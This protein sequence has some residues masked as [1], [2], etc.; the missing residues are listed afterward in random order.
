MDDNTFYGPEVRTRCLVKF[1]A[2]FDNSCYWYKDDDDSKVT[3]GGCLSN[4]NEWVFNGLTPDSCRNP[5]NGG[6]P[7]VDSRMI[8][9]MGSIIGILFHISDIELIDG[10][11]F[12]YNIAVFDN[13]CYWYK[14][15]DDSKVTNGGCLSNY[16]EWVFNGL[17]PD[18]CRNPV[19]GGNPPVDS[20]MIEVMGS[21][22][23]IL[24][25]ISDIEL[26]DGDEFRYNIAVFDNSCYW[27]KDDDDSKVT[28]GGCLSN[29]NEWV[30]NG[31]TPDS[32]RNPVNGGNPPVDSR[33]IEVMGSIIGI[34]FHISDIELIDGDEFRYNIAVFDNSCY[35]YKD[36]DDSKVTN[37]G[38]LSNYNEWVFNGL[39]PDSCKN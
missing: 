38:C 14:D 36:D 4:Y 34:L 20:R 6:N 29:Y 37:G 2:V 32:C 1:Q 9:V 26:I 7:P 17:T 31:L 22:I 27:Y 21:I 33:M 5:V 16:N 11:E 15:D 8:E 18:S 12:R 10:D 25:H 35:W 39:T 28:N 24:F 13:S 23:G 19:N 30:F 3:N